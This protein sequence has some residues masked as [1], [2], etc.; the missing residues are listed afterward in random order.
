MFTAVM[1]F[2]AKH[3]MLYLITTKNMIFFGWFMETDFFVF[4]MF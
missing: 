3:D 4:I 2:D 1:I